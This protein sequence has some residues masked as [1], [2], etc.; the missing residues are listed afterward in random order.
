MTNTLTD[1]VRQVAADIFSV[2]VDQ[3]SLATTRDDIPQWDSLHHI[4][5]VIALE[6]TFGIQFSP[7]HMEQMLSLELAALIVSE[8]TTPEATSRG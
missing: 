8:L 5:F 3:L 6:Q 1:Q 2:P 4:N 7:E